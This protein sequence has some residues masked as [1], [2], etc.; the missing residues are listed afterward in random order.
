MR[1]KLDKPREVV[2]EIGDATITARIIPMQQA[3]ELR[4]KHTR[5]KNVLGAVSDDFDQKSY[6]VDFWDATI[7]DWSGIQDEDG[8]PIPCIRA[9]KYEMVSRYAEIALRINA[10]I[11]AAMAR[12]FEADKEA[13]K[14]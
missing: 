10:D 2:V 11:E 3:T 4:R 9:N 5:S 14:N 12:T 1:L 6:A 7:V 13:E 8:T